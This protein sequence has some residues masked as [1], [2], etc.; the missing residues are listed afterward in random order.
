MVE[1][2]LV[3]S[4]VLKEYIPEGNR[5]R[6]GTNISP[7]SITVHNTDNTNKGADAKAHSKFV[8]ETGYYTYKGKKLWVSWHFTV[9][10]THIIQHLP[11]NEVGY[12]AGSEANGSSIAIEV[13]MNSDNDQELANRRAAELVATLLRN[14]GW[15][16][17]QVKRHKDWTGKNCPSLLIPKWSSFLELVSEQLSLETSGIEL[18]SAE[19]KAARE[20][21]GTPESVEDYDIDHHA[22]GEILAGTESS[23]NL[24]CISSLTEASDA[25]GSVLTSLVVKTRGEP[26]LF[27]NGIND[28]EFEVGPEKIRIAVKGPSNSTTTSLD[29]EE[30]EDSIPDDTFDA[31]VMR[32]LPP[33]KSYLKD[34]ETVYGTHQPNRR[35]GIART[36]EVLNLVADQY[37]AE[38]GIRLG[39]GDISKEGGGPISGHKSHQKGV[40]VDVRV[41]RNDSREEASNYKSAS[42]SR[43]RTQRLVE[44]FRRNGKF[45]VKYIFFNDPN[46]RG[47]SP[48]KNHD[49]HLHVRFDIEAT[50]VEFS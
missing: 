11:L 3:R 10:D 12:H 4:S 34:S 31:E 37:H 5:N 44:L 25:F 30:E 22:L 33:V 49:N 1:A 45:P 24:P 32:S 18:D 47:V 6:P 20:A 13:C 2:E 15:K 41:P 27:P 36:I 19:V 16:V 21:V 42:Y 7:S 26:L 28:I 8:R 14:F 23:T 17:E 38:F 29:T 39:I 46:I 40:D 9:D 35:F 43:Q 50:S 48:W